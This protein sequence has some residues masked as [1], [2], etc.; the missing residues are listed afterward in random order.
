MSS[1]L[2]LAVEGDAHLQTLLLRVGVQIEF[3]NTQ[4]RPCLH[5]DATDNAIPIGLRVFGIG[6]GVA[7]QLRRDG[8]A[9]VHRYGNGVTTWPQPWSEVKGLCGADVVTL[10]CLDAIDIDCGGLGALQHQH[11][12]PFLPLFGDGDFATVPCLA[13]ICVQT[14]Q[15]C[16]DSGVARGVALQIGVGGAGQR[17]RFGQRT[18]GG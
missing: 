15:V 13:H 18:G 16:G 17:H 9:V 6:M 11:H 10:T 2:H 8:F 4:L 14:C 1:F 5:V 7:E 3:L 12:L